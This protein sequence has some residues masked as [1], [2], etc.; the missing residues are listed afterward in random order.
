MNYTHAKCH[1]CIIKIMIHPKMTV[2][3]STIYIAPNPDFCILRNPIWPILK[4]INNP[5]GTF[6]GMGK[7][8]ILFP[9]TSVCRL[10]KMYHRGAW[11]P[12]FSIGGSWRAVDIWPQ[13]MPHYVRF[14]V[15]FTE[16]HKRFIG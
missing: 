3:C 5:H 15:S 9:H 10:K 2:I 16:Y 8:T 13:Y 6:F 11:D 4:C 14:D 7:K 1:A 12:Y